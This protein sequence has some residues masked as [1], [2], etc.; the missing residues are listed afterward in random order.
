MTTKC[1]PAGFAAHA[2]MSGG[3]IAVLAAEVFFFFMTLQ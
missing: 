2:A 1:L 3:V